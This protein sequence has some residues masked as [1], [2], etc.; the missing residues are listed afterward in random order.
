[1]EKN[2]RNLYQL[3][4]SYSQVIKDATRATPT[5][6]TIVD[7]VA[8]TNKHNIRK[9]GVIKTVFVIIMVF[10]ALGN[11]VRFLQRITNLYFV[12]NL[13]ISITK[14][15]GRCFKYAMGHNFKILWNPE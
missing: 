12:V 1:M 4:F 2:L 9:S 10:I 8:V 6:L 11:F 3:L 5:A 15:F 7:H 14:T 13:K